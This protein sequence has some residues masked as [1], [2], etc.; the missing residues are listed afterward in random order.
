VQQRWQFAD[1]ELAPGEGLSIEALAHDLALLPD[2]FDAAP[3]KLADDLLN[4][5]GQVGRGA[6][7]TGA[8]GGAIEVVADDDGVLM[9]DLAEPEPQNLVLS[10]T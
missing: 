3:D 5:F 6:G 2:M 8:S 10:L 4:F 1:D 9:S 7:S